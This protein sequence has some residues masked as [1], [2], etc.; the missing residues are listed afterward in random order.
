MDEQDL[1]FRITH[2][3]LAAH[4]TRLGTLRPIIHN[5]FA[6]QE[7]WKPN[8]VEELTQMIRQTRPGRHDND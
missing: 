3:S 5:I 8:G 1:V 7:S 4:F 6:E 2:P